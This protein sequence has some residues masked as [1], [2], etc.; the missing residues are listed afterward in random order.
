MGSSG[1]EWLR[2]HRPHRC[3]MLLPAT[4]PSRAAAP[5]RFRPACP[6]A[7]RLATLLWT[8]VPGQW[9]LRLATCRVLCSLGGALQGSSSLR[10]HW[11]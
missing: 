6:A 4:T 5:N 10:S 1:R 8:A 7:P 11:S 3:A 9:P 2:Y